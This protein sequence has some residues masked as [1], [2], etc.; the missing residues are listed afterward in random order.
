MTKKGEEKKAVEFLREISKLELL[1]L[2]AIGNIL[3]VEEIDPFEDYVTK[4][5]ENYLKKSRKI[6]RELL[7]LAKDVQKDNKK[8][9][10]G[11]RNGR[12][13]KLIFWIFRE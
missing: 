7:K 4:I 11:G 12:T 13:I 1:D 8:I 9:I 2:L 3:E 10:G 6:Q 5:V